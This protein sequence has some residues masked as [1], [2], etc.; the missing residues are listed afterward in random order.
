MI[1]RLQNSIQKI[2]Q[3]S[4]DVSHELKTPLTIIR[5]EIEIAL[6]KK[7]SVREYNRVL[8]SIHEETIKF[9]GIISDL[10]LLS[11]IE[12]QVQ[13]NF[14]TSIPLFEIVLNKLKNIQ[15]FAENKKIKLKIAKI[16]PLYIYGIAEFIKRLLMNLIDNAIKYTPEHGTIEIGLEARDNLAVLTV[17]D[18]GI[19][20]AEDQF[21]KI[22]DRFYRVDQ[23]RSS[24]IPGS[25]LGLAIV[26]HICTIHQADIQI[27]SKPGKGTTF[28]IRFPLERKENDQLMY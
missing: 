18:S 16:E 11:R 15:N 21:G 2:K 25:G 4:S 23:A 28:I 9:E 12:T 20:I 6:R 7:R 3:F 19:G 13:Q 10:L 27:K 17:K 1:N 24:Q 14:F 5:G 22:F 26:K 8:N